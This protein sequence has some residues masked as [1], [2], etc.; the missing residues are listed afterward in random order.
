MQ[1]SKPPKK[2]IDEQSIDM[3]I[4]IK[5]FRFKFSEEVT[6]ELYEFAKLHK[7]DDRHSFKDFWE[8]WSKVPVVVNMLNNEIARLNA[9]GYKG[10]S[11]DKMFKSARY[12]FRKKRETEEEEK[13]RKNYIGFSKEILRVIDSHIVEQI[14]NHITTDV[15]KK[16]NEQEIPISNISPADAYADFCNKMQNEI[17]KEIGLMKRNSIILN[18]KEITKK[19]KKTYKNRFFNI[20]I[21]IDYS[22]TIRPKGVSSE[23]LVETTAP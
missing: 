18:A 15:H 9:L 1:T 6:S 19:F 14:K 12:Y 11:M 22:P 5:T 7:Y 10:D 2:V 21:I 3:N 13:K 4:H 17:S 23:N 20:R 8:E 16:V